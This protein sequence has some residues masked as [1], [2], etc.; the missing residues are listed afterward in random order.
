MTGTITVSADGHDH[1]DDHLHHDGH[2]TERPRARRRT[3][4]RR[5]RA[6]RAGH[7][8]ELAAGRRRILGGQ[9]R[10]G[11]ARPRGAR[12]ADGLKAA[13]GG[14]PGS[15]A[16]RRSRGARERGSPAADPVGH[17]VHRRA[18]PG[19]RRVRV[20]LD[21]RARQAL[22]LHGRLALSVSRAQLRARRQ[23]DAHPRRGP[24]RLSYLTLRARARPAHAA[25][26]AASQLGRQ[27]AG[28][29]SPAIGGK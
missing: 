4:R 13:S 21:A 25:S 28:G 6:G 8:V 27:R 26:G 1:H 14:T 20:T 9:A 11:S 12:L 19:P 18:A 23:A 22:R 2:G 16:A 17:L 7:R 15:P 10:R 3:V 29:I 5:R 24:A